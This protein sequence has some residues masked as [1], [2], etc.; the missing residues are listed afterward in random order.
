MPN[1]PCKQLGELNLWARYEAAPNIFWN[2]EKYSGEA[3]GAYGW[4][5]Y[6]AEVTVDLTTYGVTIDDFVALQEV[7]KVLHPVSARDKLKAA[8]RR[9]SDSL[10]T[11]K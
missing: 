8:S 7:G 3:Y 9:A 10:Y 5:V 4:A 2:D 1:L 11:K 6:I